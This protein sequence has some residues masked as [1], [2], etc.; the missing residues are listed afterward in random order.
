MSISVACFCD[1]CHCIPSDMSV[2]LTV[3]LTGR[4]TG[5]ESDVPVFHRVVNVSGRTL[6]KECCSACVLFFIC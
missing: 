2:S 1:K 5:G 3:N 6:P 4:L